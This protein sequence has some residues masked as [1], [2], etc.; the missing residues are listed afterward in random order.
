M[1][2]SGCDL[3]VRGLDKIY[4][5]HGDHLGHRL[6]GIGA[7]PTGDA[8]DDRSGPHR[9]SC[10]HRVRAGHA[11][12]TEKAKCSNHRHGPSAGNSMSRAFFVCLMAIR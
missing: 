5:Q 4:I 1:Y 9:R 6:S 12:G 3:K 10:L 8:P 11:V 7:D 2:W